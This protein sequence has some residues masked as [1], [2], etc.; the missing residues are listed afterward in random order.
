MNTALHYVECMADEKYAKTKGAV[1]LDRVFNAVHKD[2][3]KSAN[4]PR[5]PFEYSPLGHA[6][7]AT[8][9]THTAT[10]AGT[11]PAATAANRQPRL[12]V[13]PGGNLPPMPVAQPKM[14]FGGSNPVPPPNTFVPKQPQPFNPTGPIV[15]P[16]GMPNFLERPGVTSPV[17]APPP[18]S[19]G[20]KPIAPPTPL[21]NSPGMPTPYMAPGPSPVTAVLPPKTVTAPM[22]APPPMTAFKPMA[23][24]P[25]VPA[26]HLGGPVPVGQPPL[27]S[28]AGLLPPSMGTVAPLPPMNTLASSVT[29]T[30]P[31][32]SA[33]PPPPPPTTAQAPRAKAAHH[34]EVQALDTVTLEGIPTHFESVINKLAPLVSDDP[35]AL[36]DIH[37]RLKEMYKK[38][39]ANTIPA[40]AAAQLFKLAQALD[41]SDAA[42]ANEAHEDLKKN[43]FHTIGSSVMIGLKRL[44][45]TA[46]KFQT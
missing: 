21:M 42:S 35:A 4:R 1:L 43:H 19:G 13:I 9:P 20:F 34:N 24:P 33:E 8:H 41:T 46:Q 28:M 10:T 23:P 25:L 45:Q 6:P 3:K 44:F 22:V 31:V 16:P 2:A 27:N 36:A 26:P 14:Q 15:P 18:M 30:L 29:P 37:N 40:P 38:V 39:Q 11:S 5:F 32:V 17:V 12:G 7:G